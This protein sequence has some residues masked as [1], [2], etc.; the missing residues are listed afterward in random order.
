MQRKSGSQRGLSLTLC[1][2]AASLA[3]AAWSGSQAAGQT[4]RQAKPAKVLARVGSSA[5]VSSADFQAIAA[6]IFSGAS[7]R[8]NSCGGADAVRS[9]KIVIPP[10]YQKSEAIGRLDAALPA[11]VLQETMREEISYSDNPPVIRDSRIRACLDNLDTY[12]WLG[13]IEDGKF[14]IR[15]QFR[16]NLFIKTR[17]MYQKKTGSGWKDKF[18]WKD[19]I[20]DQN[21]P[22]YIY[23]AL[24]LEAFLTPVVQGEGLSYSAVEVKWF[25]AEDR[26]FIWPEHALVADPFR[27]PDGHPVTREM[28]LSYKT[29]VMNSMKQR[30][31]V[32]FQNN[33]VRDRLKAALTAKVKT[34]E[35]AGKTMV[36]VS[37]SGTNVRVTFQ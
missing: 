18:D 17:I 1:G 24:C 16:S 35:F 8:A 11:K 14:K 2:V 4:L 12:P 23:V 7:F 30:L 19:V 13:S 6:Q 5:T 22:D 28:I 9:T 36:S 32:A 31:A 33:G 34:G 15:M 29:D 25:W 3:L 27:P 26:G 20:T 21:V 10:A 37:G